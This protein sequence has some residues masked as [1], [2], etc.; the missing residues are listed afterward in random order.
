[1]VDV[2]DNLEASFEALE[3]SHLEAD[4]LRAEV[5]QLQARLAAGERPLLSGAKSAICAR[6]WSMASS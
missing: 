6:G 3:Q 2:T 5:A 4:A 1:M